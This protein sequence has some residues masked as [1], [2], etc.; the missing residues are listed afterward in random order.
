MHAVEAVKTYY[1]ALA[2]KN[3]EVVADIYYVLPKMITL[4]GVV[5][6]GSRDTVKSSLAYEF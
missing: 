4:D 2:H 3:L 6:F 5:S 1:E